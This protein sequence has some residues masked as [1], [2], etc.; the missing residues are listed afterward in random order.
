[1]RS[2]QDMIYY[3]SA[4]YFPAHK[5]QAALS[6]IYNFVQ[7]KEESLP[8]AW[9]RLLKLLNALPDHPLKKNEILDI[10]YNGLIDAFRDYLDSCASSVFRE[11]TPDE[12]KILLN[13]M[14]TNEN[15]WAPP[16]PVPEPI[17]EPI[18]EHIPKPTPKKRGVLFL[19]PGD[20]QEAKK[21]MKEKGIK[22]E[23]V[24]NLP[25]IEEIHGLNLP[26]L[27]ETHCLDNPT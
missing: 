20:M 11:R 4:K 24:K 26:P 25:P 16:E 15:N 21:S 7:I 6:E 8:Q 9:G 18:I 19:S 12:A 2:P 13:N 5:K 10:F 17:S 23:D 3:F 1:M 14:L 27:E 22:A